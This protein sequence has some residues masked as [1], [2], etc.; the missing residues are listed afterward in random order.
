VF[1]NASITTGN[2]G[3]IFGNSL[4]GTRTTNG[5]NTFLGSGTSN[6]YTLTNALNVNN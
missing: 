4:L 5:T 1:S 6:A 3:V 2:T